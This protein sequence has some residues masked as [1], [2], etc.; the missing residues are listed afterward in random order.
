M[1]WMSVVLPVALMRPGRT[2]APT[3]EIGLLANSTTCTETVALA[4]I[5]RFEQRLQL[6]FDLR[7]R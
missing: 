4:R 7:G 3:T 2:T 1:A 5:V 6:R